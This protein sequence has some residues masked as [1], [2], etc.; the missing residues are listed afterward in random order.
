MTKAQTM[1]SKSDDSPLSH[2]HLESGKNILSKQVCHFVKLLQMLLINCK[3]Y[4]LHFQ[5]S[6]A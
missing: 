2:K 5:Y 4:Q 3:P 6:N 1:R